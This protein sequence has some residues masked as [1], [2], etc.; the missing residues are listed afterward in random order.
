MA[1]THENGSRT[2]GTLSKGAAASSSAV[3]AGFGGSGA[4]VRKSA[5]NP[6]ARS[7]LDQQIDVLRLA[8]MGEPR[9]RVLWTGFERECPVEARLVADCVGVIKGENRAAER[10]TAKFLAK[11]QG[12]S[13]RPKKAKAAKQPRPPAYDE[14]L[15]TYHPATPIEKRQIWDDKALVKSAIRK[16]DFL[17][18]HDAARHAIA[19]GT[20]THE[21]LVRHQRDL[22]RQDPIRARVAQQMGLTAED[23]AGPA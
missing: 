23:L 8:R 9:S 2:E 5:L 13:V 21:E 6:L 22:L 12:S 11:V 17:Q 3:A 14:S 18:P 4:T 15:P 20:L 16:N 1:F 19:E 7:S 10:Q